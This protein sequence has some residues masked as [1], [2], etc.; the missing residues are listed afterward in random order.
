MLILGTLETKMLEPMGMRMVTMTMMNLKGEDQ[1]TYERVGL[2]RVSWCWT[3][4]ATVTAMKKMRKSMIR[5]ELGTPLIKV[6]QDTGLCQVR[7]LLALDVL[8]APT[9]QGDTR[10]GADEPI[11]IESSSDEEVG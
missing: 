10:G 5:A 2:R 11:E 8:I 7:T 1:E 9:H 4:T 6:M 3:A